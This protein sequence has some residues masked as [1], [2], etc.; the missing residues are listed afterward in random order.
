MEN[1][2][3]DND[4]SSQ[5]DLSTSTD[6]EETPARTTRDGRVTRCT[7]KDW[8][9][10]FAMLALTQAEINYQNHLKEEA[11]SG[12]DHEVAFVGAGL[13]G[14]FKNT[15]ELKVMKYAEAMQSDRV[16]W[17]KAVEEE[18]QRMVSNKVWVPVN[19]VDVPKL[20]L[21]HI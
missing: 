10:D 11:K 12:I 16:G 18:H 6:I 21:I 17:T 7:S 9:K 8:Y 3:T 14:G 1:T 15:A 13:G 5:E 2:P 20:S 19:I 4:D